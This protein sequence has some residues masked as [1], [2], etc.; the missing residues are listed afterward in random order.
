MR[1]HPQ[2]GSTEHIATLP[3]EDQATATGNMHEK[4]GEDQS[5]GSGDIYVDRHTNRQTD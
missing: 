4:F 3:E 2:T 5:C 1:K